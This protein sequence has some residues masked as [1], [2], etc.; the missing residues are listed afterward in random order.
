MHAYI[1]KNARARDEK[2]E[3]NAEKTD[4]KERS[5]AK[6]AEELQNRVSSSFLAV[7]CALIEETQSKRT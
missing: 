7:P 4:E 2:C 3:G 6:P 5:E 1:H